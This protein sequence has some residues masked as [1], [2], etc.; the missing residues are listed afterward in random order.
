MTAHFF[1]HNLSIRSRLASSPHEFRI[2]TEV[3]VGAHEPMRF[4]YKFY[5]ADEIENG[6]LNHYVFC[7]L[8]EDRLVGSFMVTPPLEGRFFLKVRP[9]SHTISV[10]SILILTQNRCLPSPSARCTAVSRT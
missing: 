3:K 2:C 7:Q 10:P 9:S 6:S 4:K 8:K 5:P 1:E